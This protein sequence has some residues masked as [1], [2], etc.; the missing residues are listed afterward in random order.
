MFT[1][2][3]PLLGGR[4]GGSPIRCEP[5]NPCRGLH[6]FARRSD[7]GSQ[8]AVSRA[9]PL[10]RGKTRRSLAGDSQIFTPAALNSPCASSLMVAV[11]FSTESK[12]SESVLAIKITR[13]WKSRSSDIGTQST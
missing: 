12:Q 3:T 11:D 1:P 8:Q 9:P 13:L 10:P 7:V 2:V 4:C 6:G 5:A